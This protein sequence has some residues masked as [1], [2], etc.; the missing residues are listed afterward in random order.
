MIRGGSA[1]NFGFI[2]SDFSHPAADQAGECRHLKRLSS[3]CDNPSLRIRLIT[4]ALKT[5]TIPRFFRLSK[6]RPSVDYNAESHHG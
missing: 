4:N 6:K 5:D 3:G 1:S 2:N